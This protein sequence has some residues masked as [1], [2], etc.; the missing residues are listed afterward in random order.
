[1]VFGLE[2]VV[3]FGDVGWG[4]ANRSM[5]VGGGDGDVGVSAPAVVLGAG[6]AGC[7]SVDGVGLVRLRERYVVALATMLTQGGVRHP[8]HDER[9]EWLR[10]VQP[11]WRYHPGHD[12]VV[13]FIEP[14][15]HP[16]IEAQARLVLAMLGPYHWNLHVWTGAAAMECVRLQLGG[17][18]YKLSVAAPGS[19][20]IDQYNALLRSTAFWEEVDGPP[21]THILVWQTDGSVCREGIEEYTPYDYVGAPWPWGWVPVTAPHGLGGNGGISLRRKAAMLEVTRRVRPD[22]LPM[23]WRRHGMPGQSPFI[24]DVFF[25]NGV[26]MLNLRVAPRNIASSFSIEWVHH[27][28]PMFMHKWYIHD[29]SFCRRIF[30]SHFNIS[31]S[32]L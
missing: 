10:R 1:M 5:S 2:L 21:G 32:P 11:P 25:S 22:D 26:Q 13:V 12:R 27:P 4:G 24:E 28:R 6:G 7:V 30:L 3:L 14:R 20:H 31:D 29:I 9:L 17:F 23:W 18:E 15:C 8:R 16:L 19:M